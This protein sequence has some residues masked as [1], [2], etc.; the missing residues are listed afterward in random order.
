MYFLVHSLNK[1]DV[2]CMPKILLKLRQSFV[3][4]EVEYQKKFALSSAVRIAE[5]AQL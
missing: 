4:Q 1:L 3:S 2:V 5:V